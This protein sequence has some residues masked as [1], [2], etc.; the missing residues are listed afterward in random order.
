MN[1]VDDIPKAFQI[2]NLVSCNYYAEKT[3]SLLGLSLKVLK[4]PLGATV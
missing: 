2:E 1:D 3:K 4:T